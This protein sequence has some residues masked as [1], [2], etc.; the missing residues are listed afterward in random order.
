MF[1]S[2]L[3]SWL[4]VTYI[5][6]VGGRYGKVFL[7]SARRIAGRRRQHVSAAASR[8]CNH[9]D[10]PAVG[11]RGATAPAAAPVATAPTAPLP[12]PAATAAP[13]AA[14]VTP[15]PA[16]AL[17]T[18]STQVLDEVTATGGK[19]ATNAGQQRRSGRKHVTVA[20]QA[21]QQTLTP[22]L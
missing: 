13:A 9:A 17:A 8:L 2:Y 6:I 19:E 12:A 1:T 14:P 16:A 11:H 7:P 4:S 22:T 21:V 18:A 3:Y 5:Y 20:Q 15:A 10:Q